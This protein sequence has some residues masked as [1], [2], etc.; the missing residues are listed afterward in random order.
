MIYK[1]ILISLLCLLLLSDALVIYRKKQKPRLI[2]HEENSD[3]MTSSSSESADG[4]GVVDQPSLT[5][6][7]VKNSRVKRSQLEP[8]IM[9]DGK[10]DLS[11]I[12]NV[13]VT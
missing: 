13:G 3:V 4:D 9:L 5:S 6:E 10:I 7:P 12:A 8:V 2:C 1:S 11:K